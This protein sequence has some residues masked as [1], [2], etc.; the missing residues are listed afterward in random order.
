MLALHK[1]N[2]RIAVT[3]AHTRRRELALQG[4]GVR[5]INREHQRRQA[6]GAAHPSFHHI[7]D[8]PIVLHDCGKLAL[9]IVPRQR[10][11]VGQ[12]GMRGRE[13]AER[14]QIPRVDQFLHGDRLHE[15]LPQIAHAPCPRGG[16]QAN[17][18]LVR[19]SLHPLANN[20]VLQVALVHDHNVGA[21][22]IAARK[23]LH[24][25]HLHRLE[26]V[27]AVVLG[28]NNPDAI[29]TVALKRGNGLVNQADCGSRKTNQAALFAGT[30]HNLRSNA[31]LAR[32][33]RQ[34]QNNPLISL[35]QGMAEQGHGGF[36]MRAEGTGDAVSREQISHDGLPSRSQK[37][38]QFLR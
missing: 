31:C 37:A 21:G 16:R 38:R 22:K 17:E 5:K 34:L 8:K 18:H 20:L 9:V 32:A 28:L 36:L 25:C 15:V 24:R 3:H 35:C 6:T 19:L 30:Q 23:G 4:F 11:H 10:C 14:R 13:H 12:I 26:R 27:G 1:V 33:G 7:S 29:H 2:A